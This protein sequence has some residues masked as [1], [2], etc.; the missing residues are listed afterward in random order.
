[1]FAMI[2]AMKDQSM[3]ASTPLKVGGDWR[4]QFNTAIDKTP[5]RGGLKSS[6]IHS[7]MAT[8][9]VA[10]KDANFQYVRDGK[11]LVAKLHYRG[12]VVKTFVP[13]KVAKA[14]RDVAVYTLRNP[15]LLGL[16]FGLLLPTLPISLG[17]KLGTSMVV[18]LG[19]YMAPAG[20]WIRKFAIGAGIGSGVALGYSAAKFF[21]DLDVG[22]VVFS[23]DFVSMPPPG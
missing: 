23:S 9:I 18:A 6:V 15:G 20:S 3:I 11:S 16:G 22:A 12:D 1:M 13:S 21:T 4:Q 10:D 2:S 8:R 17:A 14:V 19:G 7:R 5:F